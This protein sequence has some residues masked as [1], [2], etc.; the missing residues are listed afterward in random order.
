MVVEFLTVSD[1]DREEFEATLGSSE[2]LGGRTKVVVTDEEGNSGYCFMKDENI[3]KLGKRYIESHAKLRYSSFFERWEVNIS[4]NDF[5]ND[6]E[7][8]PEKEIQLTYCGIDPGTGREVYKG[9]DGKRYYLRETHY[10]RERFAKWFVYGCKRAIDEG[11]E[12]RANLIFVFNGQK[13]KVRYDDWNGVAA[14]SDT[15]NEDF[16]TRTQ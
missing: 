9:V 13:E 12:P 10:P 14:Y 6:T 8:Y 3:E 5:Y 7:K 11:D 1:K 4:E 2:M 15:F 16:T